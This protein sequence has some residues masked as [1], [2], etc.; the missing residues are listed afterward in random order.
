MACK[1]CENGKPLYDFNVAAVIV[2]NSQL[3]AGLQIFDDTTNS[4]IKSDKEPIAELDIEY[5]PKCGDWIGRWDENPKY[6]KENE[7]KGVN[8]K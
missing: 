2:P 7:T 4:Y 1:Y 3:G 6:K 5:C 8:I